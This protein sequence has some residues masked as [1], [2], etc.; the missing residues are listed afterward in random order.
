MVTKPVWN[1]K[2][3]YMIQKYAVFLNFSHRDLNGNIQPSCRTFFF[4]KHLNFSTWFL[5]K[6]LNIMESKQD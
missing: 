2:N 4:A 5:K 6:S 3:M 1:V